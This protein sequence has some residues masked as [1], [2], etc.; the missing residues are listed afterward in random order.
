MLKERV[1][2]PKDQSPFTLQDNKGNPLHPDVAPNY[3]HPNKRKK[4]GDYLSKDHIKFNMSPDQ[5]K[6][7]TQ[8]A[9]PQ[10]DTQTYNSYKNPR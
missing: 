3:M 4:L 10:Y 1:F 6:T 5:M 9:W 2:D 8:E 7:T